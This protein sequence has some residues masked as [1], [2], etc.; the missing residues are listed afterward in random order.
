MRRS[1]ETIRAPPRAKVLL[2][3]VRT[4]AS[5]TTKE[6]IAVAKST[7]EFWNV[8]GPETA[9]K[10]QPMEGVNDMSEILLAQDEGNG[11]YTKLVRFHPGADTSEVGVVVHPYQEEMVILEGSLYDKT[12]KQT[13]SAGEYTCRGVGEKH[14]PFV[15]EE[16]CTLIEISYPETTKE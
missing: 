11:N 4:K 3:I 15:S 1:D 8:L 13:Y 6:V 16:G 14:G 2:R 7:T 5:T 9:D 10:W 12:W